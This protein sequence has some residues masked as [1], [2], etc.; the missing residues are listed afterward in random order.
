MSLDGVPIRLIDT[1][2][3]R[4]AE[5]AVEREGIRRS[6]ELIDACDV[7]LYLI[8]GTREAHEADRTFLDAH[9]DDARL[10]VVLTKADLTPARDGL[11]VSSATG[12][13]FDVLERAILAK[14]PGHGEGGSGAVIDSLRQKQ[15]LDRAVAAL[16]QV[17]AGAEQN[18]P[19][20]MIALDVRDALDALG[21]ITGEVTTA[22]VLTRMFSGF[23]VGK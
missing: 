22:D 23:C 15:L 2:G 14:V 12:Q 9:A 6:R 21:E 20:D 18:A 4:D 7:L 11:Q 10:V 5:N 3:L 13:G 16:D 1:A 19:I 17:R 8:D